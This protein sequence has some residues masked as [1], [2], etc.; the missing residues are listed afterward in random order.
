MKSKVCILLVFVL[1][2]SAFLGVVI[3]KPSIHEAKTDDLESIYGIGEELSHRVVVFLD[4]NP[5]ADIE[6]LLDVQGIGEY[7]LSLIKRRYR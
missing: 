6:D 3:Y 4:Q 1:I 2:L 5:S 7:R